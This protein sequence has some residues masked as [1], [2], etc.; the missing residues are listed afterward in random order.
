MC[1]TMDVLAS[2]D[3]QID[4]V[5]KLVPQ[6]LVLRYEFTHRSRIK[7]TIV[8]VTLTLSNRSGS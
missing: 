8:V 2:L 1:S 7:K 4:E 3:E 5:V 6:T